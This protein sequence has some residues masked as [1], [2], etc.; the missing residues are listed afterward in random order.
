MSISQWLINV[1][2]RAE[3]GALAFAT[4]RGRR[5][6]QW[7]PGRDDSIIHRLPRDPRERA[8]IFTDEQSIIVNPD[9][10]ALVIEDG[11]IGGALGAGHYVFEKTRVTGSLDVIWIKSGQRQLRWGLGNV[12]TREGIEVAA[13][14]VVHL[15]MGDPERF[16]TEVIQGAM[17]LT[18][19]DL[20]RLLMPRFQGVLRTLIASSG[21]TELY[22]EREG[23]DA[24]LNEALGE[25]LA[26]IGLSLIDLE[27]VEVSL[28]SE[29][30][31]ALAR[32]TMAKLGGN[33]ELEEAQTRMRVA[34]LDAQAEHAG[35]FVRAEL[36][37][38]MQ[39][40]GLD[41]MQVS[42]LDS[43]RSM[44]EAP[45]LP[46]SGG[47][48]RAEMFGRMAESMMRPGSAPAPVQGGQAAAPGPSALPP[49]AD[50]PRELEAQLDKLVE[51]LA[52]G[53]ISEALFE[54][55]SARLEARL[56]R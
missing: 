12:C 18:E 4:R 28:P 9:E 24:R 25:T 53:E 47:A 37:A 15:R 16:N 3:A 51:R 31:A 50:D 43:L 38:H 34:Q 8:S 54:R 13:N 1:G 21:A 2:I 6:L 27:I 45:Q 20:Q 11:R 35:G 39:A 7:P 40:R 48:A 46:F 56:S 17:Q 19:V 32:T 10:L 29:F 41:P 23:F 44:A 30:K 5:P 26:D 36:M 55:L 22:A 33:A 14:G 52:N 49:A 42:M